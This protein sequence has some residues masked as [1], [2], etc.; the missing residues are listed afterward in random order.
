MKIK[1]TFTHNLPVTIIK[2]G[3]PFKFV[4]V[5]NEQVNLS[6]YGIGDFNYSGTT[7]R[8]GA[9]FTKAHIE[10]PTTFTFTLTASTVGPNGVTATTV[11][12]N[13]FVAF[14]GT[15]AT[16]VNL[17][18]ALTA[19][20]AYN[21]L[22]IATTGGNSTKLSATT[23]VLGATATTLTDLVLADVPFLFDGFN[24]HD[25]KIIMNSAIVRKIILDIAGTT[26]PNW[27]NPFQL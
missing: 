5:P 26:I 24:T 14:S 8:S 9:T 7:T 20:S 11:G 12:N 25:T 1:N 17:V 15:N 22:S 4:L 6:T 27:T 3:Q 10:L 2:S 18:A 19:S 21:A 23:F 16:S 13:I